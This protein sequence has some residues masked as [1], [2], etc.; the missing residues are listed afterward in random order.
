MSSTRRKLTRR[1]LIGSGIVLGICGTA[2][3]GTAFFA[4]RGPDKQ[5][6]IGEL[7][8]QQRLGIPPLLEPTVDLD[9]TRRFDLTMQT[10][11]ASLFPQGDSETWG[12]NVSFLAP[13]LRARRGEKVAIDLHNELPEASTIHWHGMHLPA[14]MDG[15][16]HQMID[17]GAIWSPSWEIEQPAATLWYHPHPHGDTAEHVYRGI[18]GLFLI[19]DDEESQL[20]LPRSYGVDDVPL[21]L[22]DKRVTEDGQFDLSV[23]S[24]LDNFT[25][26]PS[27]GIRGDHVLVN[28]TFDP[29]FTVTTSVVRFRVLNGSNTRF[30][31]LGFTDD[32]D[33]SL[34]ASDA[35]LLQ[36]PLPELD[37][38]LVGPGERV[39]ILVRFEAGETVILRSFEQDLAV[40]SVVERQIG[41]EDT[42]D[43]VKFIAHSDL[44]GIGEFPETLLPERELVVPPDATVRTFELDG[45]T[46]INGEEMNMDR[47][48]VVVPAGALEIWEISSNGQPH[49][50]HIHGASYHVLDVDG[51]PPPPHLRGPKDTVLVSPDHPV[52]LAVQF[53]SHIDPDLPF[54]YHC[55]LLLHEDNGM[56]GQFVIVE[57]GMEAVTAMS[58]ESGHGSH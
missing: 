45:H 35:G 55:H 37:R 36:G 8:F 40:E 22:Q 32:R 14:R 39:E 17:V 42:F 7:E 58:L 2:M 54:M 19:D 13:T 29:F 47:I 46:S 51:Q 41:G 3:G 31:N 52:R 43:L 12:V 57:P 26:S 15:G 27:F 21:I 48:D 6:N 49:T 11:S 25:G 53:V 23:G 44:G 1:V 18:A 20:D 38:L 10:G 16:P 33:F 5:S 4:I 30:Y 28:G 24:F 9:G 50:F 56:M 34:L